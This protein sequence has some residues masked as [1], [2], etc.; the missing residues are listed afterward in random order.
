[1]P[2]IKSPYP[3]ALRKAVPL[4]DMTGGI[5]YSTDAFQVDG[6]YFLD[7]L[8]VD[9]MPGGG[10]HMRRTVSVLH[11]DN[12]PSKPTTLGYY[13]RSNGI[14]QLIIGLETGELRYAT[15]VEGE[16]GPTSQMLG[17]GWYRDWRG[18]Q[19]QDNFYLQ[20]GQHPPFR[21]NGASLTALATAYNADTTWS[22]AS[23]Y[24]SSGMP[25][26]RLMAVLHNRVWAVIGN[27]KLAWSFPLTLSGGAED[28]GSEDFTLVDPGVG[29][30]AITAMIAAG[31]RLFVFK[32]HG[33]WQLM[34]WSPGT[35]KLFP[36]SSESGAAGPNA[37]CTDGT[38][39]YAYDTRVGLHVISPADAGG[40]ASDDGR[41]FR[42]MLRLIRDGRVA[43]TNSSGISTGFVNDKVY[44]SLT[45]DDIRQT[46][47]LDL[48]LG[49]WTRYD[50]ALGPLGYFHSGGRS[51]PVAGSWHPARPYRILT[52]DQDGDSDF[53]GVAEHNV[54]SWLRT[55]WIY[56][57]LP[58][59]P[60]D[61]HYTDFI[62]EAGDG[63]T[64]VP[65]VSRDWDAGT[66]TAL[67]TVTADQNTADPFVMPT[68]QM[69]D[70]EYERL[71]PDADPTPRPWQTTAGADE[72]RVSTRKTTRRR[73]RFSGLYATAL[74]YTIYGPTPSKRWSVRALIPTYSVSRR[75][76]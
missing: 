64:I 38:R 9:P 29:G 17:A 36:V 18:V 39:V 2:F 58:T 49:S 24:T 20:D 28:W 27:D 72:M 61:W 51:E 69:V 66:A 60:K 32:E 50:L 53:S 30:G 16:V 12:L 5:D 1:M 35:F 74:S 46:L 11:S 4:V 57:D 54:V 52:L 45:L 73:K 25:I 59:V 40:V 3:P 68:S 47:V 14:P 34:G 15:S 67:G 8:N 56:D 48:Q 62:M 10:A 71:A 23:T 6:K 44:V 42:P 65:Y 55:A 43:E 21:W 76:L 7:A 19:V 37:V 63:Q 13:A 22:A 33:T 70:L 75:P 41:S 26:A 31:D